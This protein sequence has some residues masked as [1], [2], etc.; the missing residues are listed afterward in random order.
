MS[1]IWL[2]VTSAIV[3]G[4]I[5]LGALIWSE[6]AFT[7]AIALAAL[8]GSVELFNLFEVRG[9]EAVPTAAAVG[10]VGS[11]AFVFFAHFK[12]FG[13]YGYVTIA[14]IFL[15]FVWYMLVL[16]HVKPTKAIALTVFASL[17]SGLCLSHLVLLR[18]LELRGG[19]GWLTVLYLIVLI[20]V[21]DI[22]AWAVGR[23]IGRHKMA[24]SLSPNK[25]WEGAIAGAV[26]VLACAVLF[27]LIVQAIHKFPWFSVG[28]ALI[29]G[30]IVCIF[31]PLGDLAESMMKRDFGVKDMGSLIP[32]HGGIMDRFDSTLF[33]APVVFYYLW[34]F[35]LKFK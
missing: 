9:E 17:L 25:S 12:G 3:F 26:S 35:V 8:I 13:S 31:G 18:D 7:F 29:I 33:T 22:F 34:F 20:W 16:K 10:I 32:E 11:L 4:V 1:K 6:L 23:K 30:V 21:Y 15:S 19:W 27:R 2:R 14:I 24:P 5:L 28:V